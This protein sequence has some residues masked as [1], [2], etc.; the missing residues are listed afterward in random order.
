MHH[1]VTQLQD[2]ASEQQ[3]VEAFGD[4]ADDPL[5]GML[6]ADIEMMLPDDFLT[7]VDRASMA[8]GLEVRP[9]LVDHQWMELAWSVPSEYKIRDGQT[10]WLLKKLSQ[11][12]LS[13]ET[14]YRSKQGFEIPIDDWLRGPLRAVFEKTVLSATAKIAEYLDISQV[15]KLYAA[16]CS[17]VGR[18]G[19]LLWAIL[20]LGAWMEHYLA[21]TT[22]LT[23]QT[24]FDSKLQALQP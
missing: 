16:H 15:E 24:E 8:H 13:D 14:I 11:K 23:S 4:H 21:E 5:R 20:V 19:N 9:P 1:C 12:W 17:K 22:P 6:A 3:V 18:H 7:K 10:K 2:Y